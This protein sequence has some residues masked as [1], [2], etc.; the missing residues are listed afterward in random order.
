LRFQKNEERFNLLLSSFEDNLKQLAK[1]ELHP[2]L[3]SESRKTLLDCV[4]EK[5]LRQWAPKCQKELEM[6]KE[7]LQ[8]G[9]ELVFSIQKAVESENITSLSIKYVSYV[10]SIGRKY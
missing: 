2:K 8:Q 9:I 4:P 6:F 10:F 1:I 7:K 5:Q 3:S